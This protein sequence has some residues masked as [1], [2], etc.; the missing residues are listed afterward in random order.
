MPFMSYKHPGFVSGR[1]YPLIKAPHVGTA[2]A[3][4]DT[5]YWL[6]FVL[7]ADM[8]I[9]KLSVQST[10][11]G[12]GSSVKMGIWA[13]S[14]ISM[15]PL[16]APLAADNTGAATTGTGSID[17]AA[18]SILL[19][20]DVLYWAG[21]KTTGT[22][23]SIHAVVNLA[24]SEQALLFGTKTNNVNNSFSFADTYSNALPT[25]AEGASFTDLA[26]D[27]TPVFYALAA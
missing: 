15:R 22:P 13:N 6:P 9:S 26:T 7:P 10:A 20:K 5:I 1:R 24:S 18:L 11:G 2:I 4:I 23:A 21:I 12:A 19:E 27:V 17:S 8:N 14:L 16:G 3:A 25:L